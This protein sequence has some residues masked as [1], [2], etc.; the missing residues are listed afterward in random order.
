[1]Q[2]VKNIYICYS[3]H[4][5][6]N[7]TNR[8]KNELQNATDDNG[9]LKYH[10]WFD[11][12]DQYDSGIIIGSDFNKSME[13]GIKNSDCIFFLKCNGSNSYD[14]IC[15]K[16]L[17]YAINLKKYIIPVL[18]ENTK[19][20]ILT[21]TMSH[22]SALS[23][24]DE[25]NN[26]IEDE[27]K[28]LFK[29]I[30]KIIDKPEN[31]NLEKVT[32][33]KL[34]FK[35]HRSNPPLINSAN[36]VSR[37]WLINKC[38]KW[39][40]DSKKNNHIFFIVG[41]PGSGKTTFINDGLKKLNIS[42]SHFCTDF[43]SN[44]RTVN[45]VLCNL[46]S[47]LCENND[48]YKN[49]IFDGELLN[50]NIFN[51]PSDVIFT[52]FFI[53]P[54]KSLNSN[55]CLVID[56]FDEMH[57][58][59]AIILLNILKNQDIS[60][61]NNL[62]FI[63]TCRKEKKI[64]GNIELYNVVDLDENSYDDAKEFIET[65]FKK[66]DIKFSDEYINSILHSSE[67]NFL[68]LHFY[69]QE[70]DLNKDKLNI[71]LPIG[72]SGQLK[73]FFDRKF[74]CNSNI[75]YLDL[76]SILEILVA[77]YSNITL[78]MMQMLLQEHDKKKMLEKIS[79]LNFV[80]N[81][82]NSNISIYHKS[83]KEFL[84][85]EEKSGDYFIDS[86]NGDISFINLYLRNSDNIEYCEKY[87]YMNRFLI[88]HASKII[89]QNLT[90]YDEIIQDLCKK[91]KIEY[92]ISNE[93]VINLFMYFFLN[94][95]DK[96]FSNIQKMVDQIDSSTII[97]R[98]IFSKLI[99]QRNMDVCKNFINFYFNEN[100][101]LYWSFF[102]DIFYYNNDFKKSKE[103][104]LNAIELANVNNLFDSQENRIIKSFAYCNLGDVLLRQNDFPGA[105]E[106]YLLALKFR[107]KN[108]QMLENVKNSLDL[109]HNYIRLS[110]VSDKLNINQ[111]KLEYLDLAG[112]IAIKASC[113]YS[114]YEVNRNI[115]IY[116]SKLGDIEFNN[117][118]SEKSLENYESAKEKATDN[119]NRFPG[120]ESNWDLFLCNMRIVNVCFLSR[121]MDL[122]RMNL[123]ESEKICKQ[124]LDYHYSFESER[125][126]A[127][128]HAKMGDLYNYENDYA[129]AL[130]SYEICLN[131]NLKNYEK[132]IY[133][134]TILDLVNTYI[135]LGNLYS[136]FNKNEDSLNYFNLA[137][138]ITLINK[139]H[140]IL[141]DTNHYLYLIYNKLITISKI[142]QK[143]SDAKV[144]ESNLNKISI[145]N[146]WNF[147]DESNID[148]FSKLEKLITL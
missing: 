79:N 102:G 124:N 47:G 63:V 16:E 39:I 104:N 46:I 114:G 115:C 147:N 140:L 21:C 95:Q 91:L 14:S 136:N 142:L 45:D 31:I 2:I 19:D 25:K 123:H 110:T 131:T 148:L 50:E 58:K 76:T 62:S 4:H 22:I 13:K 113:I 49:L 20:T 65:N 143:Y 133:Y 74:D 125:N 87:N 33:E 53:E 75:S 71:N 82:I 108:F 32:K 23:I 109:F 128:V 29:E 129:Q 52:S 77:S 134:I 30:E 112:K 127:I 9:A 5:F 56:S 35:L 126:L 72:L 88:L 44:T 132:T 57:E 43:K 90:F 137:L 27:F 37:N 89:N 116:Y 145:S 51:N 122:A 42:A 138:N 41:G 97:Y 78:E 117:K 69:F 107:I 144:Y 64:L 94:E 99:K 84:V 70:Y 92:E 103:Y 80:T 17:Q 24:F 66:R 135:R 120:W 60:M 1:M 83:L 40:N 10:V 85:N 7:A 15:T 36:I 18:L 8:F 68:Y 93:H 81:N 55:V 67:N 146:D 141:T 6:K 73:R 118:N 139:E 105:K 100:D 111:E 3:H 101:S 59:D 28:K 86:K 11:E 98:E 106:N 96:G 12:N 61:P 26:I 121:K 54:I 34:L 48:E 130:I 119:V 38:S